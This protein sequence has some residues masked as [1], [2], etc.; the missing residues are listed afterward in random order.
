MDVPHSRKGAR[1]SEVPFD[2]NGTCLRGLGTN[3]HVWPLNVPIITGIADSH[4][5]LGITLVVEKTS[6]GHN[7]RVALAHELGIGGWLAY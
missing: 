4:Y 5:G 3:N 6:A 7:Y 2:E 1:G